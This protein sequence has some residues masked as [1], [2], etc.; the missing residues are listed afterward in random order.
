MGDFKRSGNQ[1]FK[2]RKSG[3][4]S[5]RFGRRDS[6]SSENRFE[7]RRDD[8]DREGS[9]RKDFRRQEG[10]RDLEMFDIVCDKCGKRS[11]VPFKPT[12]GKPV[13]CKECF[14]KTDGSDSKVS[15]GQTSEEFAKINNKLD[16]IM[17]ALNI[18]P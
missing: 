8:R 9:G 5:G 7:R 14:R 11:Q 16:K 17:K 13:F 6:Y 18:E 3:G 10:G 1:D 4:F 12:S 15:S 2:R